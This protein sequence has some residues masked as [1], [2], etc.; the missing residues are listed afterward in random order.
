MLALQGAVVWPAARAA[1]AAGDPRLAA[2]RRVFAGRLV[3]Q[4]AAAYDQARLGWNPRFDGVRPLA[5][6]FPATIA[7]IRRALQWAQHYGVR[8]AVRSG[9]HSFAGFSTTSG[10]VLDLTRLAEIRTSSD[11][12]ASIAAGAALGDVYR[13]LW[14]V[15]R[16]VP[17]G[18]CAEVGVSG[19]T[20]GGGHGY[21]SR[22]LGLACDNVTQAEVVTADGKLRVCNARSYPDLFWAL[23]GA[24]AGSFGVVTKLVFRT[25]PVDSVTTVNLAWPWA[26]ARQVVQAWQTFAPAAP[27]ALSCS[28]AFAPGPP[29]GGAPQVAMNGQFFGSRDQALAV[30]APLTGAV[31]PSKVAAVQRPFINAVAYFASDNPARRAFAA[32]SSY[33]VAPLPAAALDAIVA[34]FEAASRDPRL[35]SVGAQLFAHGGAINRVGAD[36]TAFAHR[37]AL[38]SIR[39]T[40]FW[41][42]QASADVAAA[43]LGWVRG[44]HAALRPYVSGGAVANYADPELANWLTAY[45]GLHVKRLAAVKRRY[46]PHNFFRFPQ[47]V[48]LR[49]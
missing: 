9:G 32:K 28:L 12:T 13:R 39:Y 46:D 1:R 17:L 42:T 45:Y 25:H 48:P 4:G 5:V 35:A 47:S 49:A 33:A 10:L 24:G 26:D 15:G 14:S 38:F 7:D 36:A 20:L 40:A 11:G 31:R 6:A 3:A 37:S 43:S 16:A 2:L 18:T 30:L 41:T 19:L 23:R 21:S 27:D 22:A 8:L 29:G 44:V 34:A